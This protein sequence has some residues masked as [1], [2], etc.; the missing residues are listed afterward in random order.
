MTSRKDRYVL[1]PSVNLRYVINASRSQG[2]DRGSCTAKALGFGY[3]GLFA[4]NEQQENLRHNGQS[5]VSKDAGKKRLD[6]INES[7]VGIL[8]CPDL[9]DDFYLNILDWSIN[10]IVSIALDR[11]VYCY[12]YDSRESECLANSNSFHYITALKSMK[13]GRLM[14]IA[15]SIGCISIVDMSTKKELVRGVLPN[16]SRVAALAC[17]DNSG[18]F[19][20]HLLVTGSKTGDIYGYDLR[21]KLKS[22]SFCLSGHELEISGLQM[23]PDSWQLCSGG[24]DNRVFIWDIRKEK[25]LF[26]QDEYQSAVKALS[27]C[28]WRRHLLAVGTG[29]NDRRACIWN[30]STNTL[31]YAVQTDSQ[32]CGIMWAPLIS[33]I[34]TAHGYAGN[35]L[36]LWPYP[37]LEK[38]YSVQAHDSR[39][40]HSALAP[41]GTT[42]AT[43]AA[44]ESLKF[45]ELYRKRPSLRTP[46]ANK[47]E[48]GL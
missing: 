37:S 1:S 16:E 48:F 35:D 13:A 11:S 26:M 19:S 4:H 28:P 12:Y 10:N 30:S 9:R 18:M 31:M 40:L 39:I 8:D 25:P 21:R 14:A 2:D 38:I 33:E 3:E 22:H 24:N 43:C 7:P 34:I 41:D 47:L 17:K 23:A 42:I 6:E 27:W 44:N 29:T 46:S 45:W 32:I 20:D 5:K 15:N 36:C